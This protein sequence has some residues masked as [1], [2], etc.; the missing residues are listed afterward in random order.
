[1]EIQDILKWTDEQLLAKTG[2]HLDSLQ[3]AI[4]EGVWSHQDYKEI[5]LT[6][7]R[8]YAHVKKEAWK[9]WTLLSDTIGEDVKKS[10]VCSLLE[11][12]ELSNRHLQ[13]RNGEG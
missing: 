7:Q 13:N 4:L 10:N 12:A 8:S 5:A 6:H 9:L 2:K 1:M 3:K 11:K